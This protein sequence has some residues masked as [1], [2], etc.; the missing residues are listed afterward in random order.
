MTATQSMP[1][2]VRFVPCLEVL[3]YLDWYLDETRNKHRVFDN[4][5]D[6]L[7]DVKTNNSPQAVNTRMFLDL[8]QLLVEPPSHWQE[9]TYWIT[10]D[11]MPPVVHLTSN[12]Q[13]LQYVAS[14]SLNPPPLYQIFAASTVPKGAPAKLGSIPIH[15]VNT[16]SEDG[17]TLLWRIP[18]R[19]AAAFLTYILTS[20]V[21]VKN[22]DDEIRKYTKQVLDK[23]RTAT[24]PP[25][26]FDFTS[27]IGVSEDAPLA[28]TSSLLELEERMAPA[29]VRTP[30]EKD[31]DD[32]QVWTYGPEF[33]S[34]SAIALATGHTIPKPWLQHRPPPG[35]PVPLSIDSPFKYPGGPAGSLAFIQ[36]SAGGDSDDDSDALSA[37]ED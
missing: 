16:L 12:G 2:P 4:V 7:E 21:F 19:S 13:F 23:L 25:L 35:E 22:E 8:Y 26:K 37:G 17:A 27:R 5:E 1:A 20:T 31:D 11:Q 30:R 34:S 24:R 33:S 9:Q 3:G 18:G 29:P 14:T 6:I 10:T 36:S 15:P 32:N 28:S